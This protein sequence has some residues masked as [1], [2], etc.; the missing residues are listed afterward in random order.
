MVHPSLT[1]V[2]RWTYSLD[3]SGVITVKQSK[4]NFSAFLAEE[5]EFTNSLRDYCLDHAEEIFAWQ[6]QQKSEAEQVVAP[7]E[8]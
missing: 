4:E 3:G 5:E 8:P 6:M 1:Q 7:N 2:Y